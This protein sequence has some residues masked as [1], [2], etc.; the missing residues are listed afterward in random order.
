MPKRLS[1]I[2]DS[3]RQLGEIQVSEWDF[4]GLMK[5]DIKD[6]EI[7]PSLRKLGNKKVIDWDFGS[8]LPAVH[9]FAHQEVDVVGWVK[10][11]ARYKVME[12]D[13]RSAP[14]DDSGSASDP[15]AVLSR[16]EEKQALATRL[17]KFLQ[18][19]AVSLIDEADRAQIRI[20][21]IEPGVLR[22][23]LV[24][25]QKDL[26]AVLGR[27][28]ATASAIRNLL[29]GAAAASG[30]NVLLQILSHEEE[31]DRSLREGGGG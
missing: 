26:K 24:V 21:E 14:D 23:K 17:R 3:L 9:R 8:V 6:L 19:V 4:M 13:F 28:G 30:V 22:F 16:D 31:L 5:R 12:W 10:R 20:Q 15:A 27:D 25:A 2:T 11:A 1:E 7:V 18:F 29:K